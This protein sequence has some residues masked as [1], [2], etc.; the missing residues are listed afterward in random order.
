MGNVDRT[1]RLRPA[2]GAFF[3]LLAASLA[4]VG[5]IRPARAQTG[6]F[7]TTGEGLNAGRFVIYPSLSVDLLH[8]SNVRYTSEDL[9]SLRD[10]GSGEFLVKPRIL[11]DL[12]IGQGRIRWTYSPVYRNYTNNA[13]RL[14]RQ[15]SHY[16]DLEGAFQ[17]G[18]ALRVSLRD[19]YV[20]GVVEVQEVDRGGELA[21]GLTPFTSD[22]P[23]MQ[24]DL[25]LGARQGVSILPRYTRVR[26]EESPTA[27]FLSYRRRQ[28]EGRYNF[29]LSPSDVLYGFY[30]FEGTDQRRASSIFPDL[31]LDGRSAGIGLTRTINQ[32]VTTS[33]AAGYKRITFKGGTATDFAG[34]VADV[35]AALQ[36]SDTSS[37]V[38]VLGRQPYQS[39]FLDNSYYLDNQLGLRFL[40]QVG[41]SIYWEISGTVRSNTYADRVDLSVRP[42]TPATK[43]CDNDGV[44]DS[45]DCNN[46]NKID[47]LESL[48][49]VQQSGGSLDCPSEGSRRRDLAVRFEIGA[50]Y[51]LLRTLRFFV[52][53]NTD[54][55][56]SNVE[57]VSNGAF[58]DPFDYN[59]KRVFFRIEAGWL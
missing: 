45:S 56:R 30:S 14:P 29:R 55:R 6:P 51:R 27:A 23:S 42:D 12:P 8:D 17:V 57:Q 20:R 25:D 18:S 54:R 13:F 34:L 52:G 28:L 39:F 9:P 33:V 2:A 41:R 11:V 31:A 16:F 5:E 22:E 32:E 49:C 53:Y 4:I 58:Y 1:T 46:N 26:F 15:F 35:N 7:Q 59:I 50:G 21:F 38:L 19:H 24:V 48:Y 40:Q 37:L 43:D 36:L 3:L 44:L 10:L 47:S